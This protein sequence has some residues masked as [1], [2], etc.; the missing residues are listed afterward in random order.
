MKVNK[1]QITIIVIIIIIVIVF[2]SYYKRYAIQSI[3]PDSLQQQ[4]NNGMTFAKPEGIYSH[5]SKWEGGL[6]NDPRDPGGLTNRGVTIGTWQTL[7]PKLFGLQGTPSELIAMTNDQWE[8]IIN[9]YWDKT[10][11]SQLTDQC[12]A[13]AI[14]DWYWGSGGWGLYN[15]VNAINK[16]YNQ[17]FA[18][19]GLNTKLTSDV[20]NFMNSVDAPELFTVI[21][22]AHINYYHA[23]VQQKPS[24]SYALNG[25]LNRVNDVTC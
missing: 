2:Y 10:N 25:W 18:I 4:L 3:L 23:L 6:V 7:A 9:Y 15:V 1:K 8:K 20:I 11:A 5:I 12:V 24:M 17:T 13:N 14:V 16:Y 19:N 22:N 21:Q